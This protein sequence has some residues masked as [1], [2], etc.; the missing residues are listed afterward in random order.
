MGE[1]W[2]QMAKDDRFP[3]AIIKDPKY[4]SQGPFVN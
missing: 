1:F 3:F 4:L 2:G